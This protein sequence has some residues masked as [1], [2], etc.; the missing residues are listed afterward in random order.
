METKANYTRVGSLVLL[1]V[2]ALVIVAIWLSVGLQKKVYHTYA[3]YMNEPVF[4]LNIQAPVKF[5][6]VSVGYVARIALNKENPQQVLLLLDVDQA[7]PI[8]SSTTAVLQSQGIT[9]IRYIE[10]QAGGRFAEPLTRLANEPYPVIPSRPSLLV[11]LDTALKDVTENFQQVADAVSTVLD[12]DNAI[13]L[14][15][16]LR[17]IEHITTVVS[18]QSKELSETIDNASTVFKNTARASEKLPRAVENIAEGSH[19]LVSMAQRVGRAGSMVS[20]TMQTGK[21]AMQQITNQT[22]PQVTSLLEQLDDVAKTVDA[23]TKELK[24]NPSMII[25]GKAPRRLGPGER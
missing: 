15:N 18:Q 17:N 12:K 9:G 6:G 11:Q 14:K 22:M 1:L 5:N 3:V 19:A 2:A 8:T 4:G 16:T 10:L 7:A 20:S 23:L 21:R 13:A 24:Q 25:R